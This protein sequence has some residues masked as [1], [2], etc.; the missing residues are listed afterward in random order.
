MNLFHTNS[1]PNPLEHEGQFT[2]V[3]FA[4]INLNSYDILNMKLDLNVSTRSNLVEMSK[5]F[6]LKIRVIGGFLITS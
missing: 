4:D 3:H 6:S 1:L 5:T 2:G